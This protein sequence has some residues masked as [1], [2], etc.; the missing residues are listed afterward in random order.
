[1]VNTL[2]EGMN[3]EFKFV[4]PESKTVPNL[5]PESPEFQNMPE[6]F[7]T[8]F[9][10]GLVEWTCIQAIN[11]HIDWPNEQTVGIHVNLS[12]TAPTPPG[13]EIRVKVTLLEIHGRRL[14]FAVE[15]HDEMDEICSGTHERFIIDPT[16][17]NA[18]V[19]EKIQRGKEH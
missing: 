9:M 1:M 17:F 11:P 12:H 2:K 8:G 4:V 6:V 7:A 19:N 3:H 5:Y 13:I 14:L 15:A 18:K 16:K 10:V